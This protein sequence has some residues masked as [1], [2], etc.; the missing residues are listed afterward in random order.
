MNKD[1][2]RNDVTSARAVRKMLFQPETMEA[3]MYANVFIYDVVGGRTPGDLSAQ[4][5]LAGLTFGCV[6]ARSV[7]NCSEPR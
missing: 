5:P 3:A 2:H 4:T 1:F 7:G 6:N